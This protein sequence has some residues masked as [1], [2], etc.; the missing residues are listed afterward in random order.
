M[1]KHIP[2]KDRYFALPE[3][4]ECGLTRFG[5]KWTLQYE[6]GTPVLEG[7][8]LTLADI[9]GAGTCSFK[10]PDGKGS[11]VFPWSYVAC[12][13]ANYPERLAIVFAV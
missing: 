2:L 13:M 1:E 12:R 7:E 11:V 4:V 5:D 8:D 9:E 10:R 3:L 6:D